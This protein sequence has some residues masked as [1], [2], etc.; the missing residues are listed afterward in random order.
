MGV[1]DDQ[2]NYGIQKVQLQT[3]YCLSCKTKHVNFIFSYLSSPVCA[4][5]TTAKMQNEGEKRRSAAMLYSR[6]TEARCMSFPF[7]FL[8]LF[9]KTTFSQFAQIRNWG[10]FSC[11]S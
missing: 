8:P 11:L 10:G 3:D 7:D 6:S 5:A 2:C 4:A 1:R 9:L